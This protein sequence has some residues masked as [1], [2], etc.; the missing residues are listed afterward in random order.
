MA[1]DG[2]PLPRGC[3]P[4]PANRQIPLTLNSQNR[5]GNRRLFL[6]FFPP[7]AALPTAGR[8]PAAGFPR[9]P[10]SRPKLPQTTA[11]TL[12]PPSHRPTIPSSHSPTAH[13]RPCIFRSRLFRAPPDQPGV[14]PRIPSRAPES[15]SSQTAGRTT[16]PISE[17]ASAERRPA[18]NVATAPQSGHGS[19]VF[20]T[21][22]AFPTTPLAAGNPHCQRISHR[23]SAILSATG[24][25]PFSRPGAISTV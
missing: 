18:V 4:A 7:P 17:V 15:A 14:T 16:G 25:A 19:A 10:P 1:L 12:A 23:R 2:P 11:V 22:P 3:E 6:N 24:P 21:R 8:F 5:S 20:P 13:R 9:S